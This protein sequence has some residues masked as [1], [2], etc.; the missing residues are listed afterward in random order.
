MGDNRIFNV[1]GETE[2]GLRGTLALAFHLGGFK[3]CVGYEFVK[4]KGLILY[5][6]VSNSN[7]NIIVF[8]A[9]IPGELITGIV[10]SWLQSDQAKQVPCEGWDANA[11]HDGDN[12]KGWR[13]YLENWGDVGGRWG[14]IACVKPAFIWYGK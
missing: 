9:P 6:Y 7:K 14:V 2:T 13:V 5:S 10:W 11:D 1:N 3:T 12:N 4:E 8:P